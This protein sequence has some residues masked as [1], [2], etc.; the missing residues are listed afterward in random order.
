MKSVFIN[1]TI[2]ASMAAAIGLLVMA[3]CSDFLDR[4]PLGRYTEQDIPAGSFDSQVFGV[5]AKMRAFGVAA[6]PLLAIHNF[7]SDDAD[8]GSSTTDGIAQEN[9]YDNFQY[10]KDEWLL[11]SYWADHYAL[12]IAAN[13]VIADIDSLGAADAGTL[14]NKAE[15]KMMRAHAYFDLARTYGDVPKIDFK[16]R[17]SAEA[18]IAKAPV[19]EIFALIDADLNEAAATLPA[20]WES[21]YIGRLTSGAAQAL[22]AKTY[23]W[24]QNWSAALASAKQVIN[25]G[26]YRLATDYSSIFRETGE[27]NSESIFEIQAYYSVTQ[28]N[29]G[30]EYA[31]HQGVRGS[32]AWDLGWGWNTPS[33]A[34]ADAF[35]EGDPRK[36]GTLLYAGKINTPYN[37]AVPAA[38]ASIPRPYWNKKT[39]TNPA[40]RESTGSRFGRWMNLRV[41][42]Y[43]DVLLMAAEAANEIG[44]EQNTTDALAWLEQVRGRA[45]GNNTAILPKITTTDPAKLRTAI[46]QERRVELGMENERF[47][48][49][50]RWGLA[51]EVLHA[52]GKT[53]YQPRNRYLPIPQPEIDKSGGVLIQNPEY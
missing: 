2:K 53:G 14:I 20:S 39:Y 46:Q 25:S 9:F 13:A 43:A 48:D 49:L 21:Q 3:G 23:L 7:R 6:M 18:N 5:Y 44:G 11:N 15:A 36:D 31:M 38:T 30:L 34:L 10:T 51:Q 33:Q 35:E 16:V 45:R 50:V 42:R 12:I 22:H 52:A 29:L 40:L 8:K 24:R 28:T 27:N 47:F 41:I 1:K 19:A 37:E 4:E 17:E 26:T 32:G